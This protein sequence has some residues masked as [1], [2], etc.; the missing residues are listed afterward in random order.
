MER[1]GITTLFPLKRFS[2]KMTAIESLVSQ[3][4]RT[5]VSHFIL[6]FVLV[7]KI[8]VGILRVLNIGYHL[9]RLALYREE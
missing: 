2:K 7:L 9:L 3:T 8:A 1:I 4:R 5:C 6:P